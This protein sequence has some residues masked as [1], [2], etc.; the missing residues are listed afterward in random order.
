MFRR[1]FIPAL[2]FAAVLAIGACGGSKTTTAT[3]ELGSDGGSSTVLAPPSN[4]AASTAGATAAPGTT[5]QT[6]GTATTTKPLGTSTT[7]PST[8]KPTDGS[9]TTTRR[10]TTTTS[11]SGSAT[12]LRPADP[13]YADWCGTLFDRLVVVDALLKSDTETEESTLTEMK[14]FFATAT[15]DAPQPVAADW[16]YV[17]GLVQGFTSMTAMDN[18]TNS[19]PKFDAATTR[20]EE[21]VLGN[22]GFDMNEVS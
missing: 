15:A 10:R 13:A 9:T 3:T 18:T 20:I 1:F 4:A 22:C 8:T 21:W 7:N 14:E 2:T 6:P 17:N 5:I 16:Q 12:T 11:G 19:D